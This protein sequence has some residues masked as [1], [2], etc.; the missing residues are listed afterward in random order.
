MDHLCDMCMG[1]T[2][3]PLTPEDCTPVEGACNARRVIAIEPGNPSV[4]K[5]FVGL[6]KKPPIRG[7]TVCDKHGGGTEAAREAANRNLEVRAARKLL[8]TYGIVERPEVIPDVNVAEELQYAAFRLRMSIQ[9]LEEKVG[10]SFDTDLTQQTKDGEK[11][12]VWLNLLVEERKQEQRLLTD[13]ARLGIEA[14][15]QATRDR[16]A[17]GVLEA[18]RAVFSAALASPEVGLT[19]AQSE[20]LR[21]VIGQQMKQLGR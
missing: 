12:S 10:S 15:S 19:G 14:K 2:G 9:W 20:A 17:N 18:I 6:C 16:L 8:G 13:M 21:V 11:P 5:H 1:P 3:A 7:G 4:G